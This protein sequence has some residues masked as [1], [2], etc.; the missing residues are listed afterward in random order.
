M[1]HFAG[2][3]CYS[4]QF[5][6]RYLAIEFEVIQLEL[7][8]R[9]KRS[10]ESFVFD[11]ES[12]CADVYRQIVN[13]REGQFMIYGHSLGASI[14]LQVSEMLSQNNIAPVCLVV[15]GNSGPGTRE[16]KIRYNLEY[17]DFKNE[18]RLLGGVSDELLN[19]KALFDFFEPALRADFRI[20]DTMSISTEIIIRAPIYALMGSEEEGSNLI[21]NWG[22]FTTSWFNY[23][24]L[25]G[26]HFFIHQHAEQV[27]AIINDC[28]QRSRLLCVS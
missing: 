12:A 25:K 5:M 7:P 27:A 10:G 23:K 11:F 13:K 19:D 1:I 14:G 9:G 28:Y 21:A 20:A 2:G 4:F 17:E 15:S 6:T 26:D 16:S 8:G 22:K 18:L 24:I 3:N